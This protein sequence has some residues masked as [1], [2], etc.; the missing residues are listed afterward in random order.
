MENE[1]NAWSFRDIFLSLGM[2][3]DPVLL[4]IGYVGLATAG[5][6]YGIFYFLGNATGEEGSYGLDNFAGALAQRPL[7]VGTCVPVHALGCP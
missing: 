4:G 5:F 1:S 6:V 7:G 2:A 3:M